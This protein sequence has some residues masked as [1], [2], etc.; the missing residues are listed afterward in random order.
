MNSPRTNENN[1]KKQLLDANKKVKIEIGENQIESDQNTNPNKVEEKDDTTKRNKRKYGD[2]GNANQN[3][4]NLLKEVSRK[5]FLLS[6]VT[7]FALFIENNFK[8]QDPEK[9]KAILKYVRDFA[10][11]PK[12]PDFVEYMV[13]HVMKHKSIEGMRKALFINLE[14]NEMEMTELESTRVGEYLEAF[15]MII[16]S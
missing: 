16:A 12:I 5:D 14:L 8:T 1:L 4:V 7:N 9:K 11:E 13:K 10:K 3:F 2:V 15:S 6:K